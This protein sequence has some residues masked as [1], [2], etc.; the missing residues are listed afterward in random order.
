MHAADESVPH[1]SRGHPLQGAGS[2]GS[3]VQWGPWGGAGMA[4]QVPGF[5]QRMARLGLG[6]LLPPTGLAALSH[7]LRSAWAPRLQQG[8]PVTVGRVHA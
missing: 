1:L 3:S 7:A 6:A 5:M 4:V 2:P 8:S